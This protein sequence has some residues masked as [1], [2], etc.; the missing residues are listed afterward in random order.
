MVFLLSAI[1]T[2]VE[3]TCLKYQ[4]VYVNADKSVAKPQAGIYY[5]V[6]SLCRQTPNCDNYANLETDN[7]NRLILNK[8]IICVIFVY[9]PQFYRG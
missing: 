1:T 9:L 2:K 5:A 3:L 8:E 4:S 6:D 7:V